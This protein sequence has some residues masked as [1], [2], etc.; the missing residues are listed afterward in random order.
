MGWEDIGTDHPDVPAEFFYLRLIWQGAKPRTP[1]NKQT[2]KQT[3]KT[4]QQTNKQASK[5]ASK[6]TNKQTNIHLFFS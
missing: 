5:Q 6:Q 4:K 2:N 3:K 1:T